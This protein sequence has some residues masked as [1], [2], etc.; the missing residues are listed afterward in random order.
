MTVLMWAKSTGMLSMFNERAH[1]SVANCEDA[2]DGRPCSLPPERAEQMN[3]SFARMRRSTR[4]ASPERGKDS[5]LST[6]LNSPV[7]R[8][9]ID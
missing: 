8:E 1:T 4:S 5:R 9:Y 3:G 6:H 7:M 2:R